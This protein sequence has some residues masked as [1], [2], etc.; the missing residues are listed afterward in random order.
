MLLIFANR[1]RCYRGQR[2]EFG[3]WLPEREQ[4]QLGHLKKDEGAVRADLALYILRGAM[5][6]C[7]FSHQGLEY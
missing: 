7:S 1:W 6:S 3:S 2:W 5:L 4:H